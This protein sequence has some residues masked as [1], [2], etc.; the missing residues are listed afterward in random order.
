M[1]GYIKTFLHPS[2]AYTLK[3]FPQKNANFMQTLALLA[4]QG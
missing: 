4:F 2:I 3:E 1:K